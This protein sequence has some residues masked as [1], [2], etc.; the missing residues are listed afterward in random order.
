MQEQSISDPQ[1]KPATEEPREDLLLSPAEEAP[2][3]ES[4]EGALLFSLKEG[5][6]DNLDNLKQSPEKLD[7]S[8]LLSGP[9]DHNSEMIPIELKNGDSEIMDHPNPE[10]SI[11]SNSIM[12]NA[13]KEASLTTIKEQQS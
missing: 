2:K 3:K 7:E 11:V 1:Q 9:H 6:P 12:D 8:M 13:G 5:P 4:T 10:V